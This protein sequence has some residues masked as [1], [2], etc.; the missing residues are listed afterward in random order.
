LS[1]VNGTLQR[2][3]T[4]FDAKAN[5]QAK[6]GTL[7]GVSALA[8]YLTTRS[9]RELIITIMINQAMENAAGLKRFENELCYFL[10]NQA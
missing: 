5:I 4:S 6:T 2:R 1:G 10:V 8:G 7:N 3:F 9:K